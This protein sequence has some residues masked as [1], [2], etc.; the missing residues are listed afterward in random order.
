MSSL[1]EAEGWGESWRVFLPFSIEAARGLIC[2]C[3]LGVLVEND[4]KHRIAPF[5]LWVP[6]TLLQICVRVANYTVP[7]L[8]N[9]PSFGSYFNLTFWGDV[10]VIFPG[11][12]LQC[13]D[14]SCD[15]VILVELAVK[16]QHLLLFAFKKH[17]YA[18]GLAWVLCIEDI[19]I[20][21]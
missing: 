1:A 20:S 12:D 16:T 8:P 6:F 7:A 3:F 2:V 11:I 9:F 10:G 17:L 13:H 19:C 18:C 5:D 21:M 14:K 15:H 4:M